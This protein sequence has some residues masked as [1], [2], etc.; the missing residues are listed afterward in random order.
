[1]DTLQARYVWDKRRPA[2]LTLTFSCGLAFE[3]VLRPMLYA[4]LQR[5][6]YCCYLPTKR[7]VPT[8]RDY[9]KPEEARYVCSSCD[10]AQQFESEV[11]TLDLQAGVV[12][13]LASTFEHVLDQRGH[14][15]LSASV[16]AQAAVDEAVRVAR[17]LQER[18]GPCAGAVSYYEHGLQQNLPMNE[19]HTIS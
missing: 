5:V 11:F 16:L 18:L 2:A 10:E 15:C 19:W 6:T 13:G 1:M 7:Y 17:T 8:Y 9:T 4:T 14:C 3:L 12:R